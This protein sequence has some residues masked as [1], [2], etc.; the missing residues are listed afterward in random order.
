MQLRVF[1][2]R[3]PHPVIGPGLD[4]LDLE[5]LHT[6]GMTVAVAAFCVADCSAAHRL[7]CK[8]GFVGGL[9][10]DILM[11]HLI[12]FSVDIAMRCAPSRPPQLFHRPRL[13]R[14]LLRRQL[15]LGGGE[16]F[17]GA[18]HFQLGFFRFPLLLGLRAKLARSAARWVIA[19]R[20]S[21][22]AARIGGSRRGRGVRTSRVGC[23]PFLTP[24]T[25]RGA[26]LFAVLP[27]PLPLA[28][29]LRANLARSLHIRGL[30]LKTQLSLFHRPCPPVWWSA[31]G[32]SRYFAGNG[33]QRGWSRCRR[34][35]A[36]RPSWNGSHRKAGG[37]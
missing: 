34:T 25:L 24:Q 33:Q 27:Q 8:L 32:K 21:T 3:R 4:V 28:F 37:G 14:R 22:L 19:L 26:G 35:K 29:G 12:D 30:V 6:D 36:P 15:F 13:F 20:G 2:C 7:A 31:D 17:I 1:L 16:L 9:G 11:L 18:L 10:S 5:L 23:W